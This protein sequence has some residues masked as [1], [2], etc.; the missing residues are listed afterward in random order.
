MAAERGKKR[1]CVSLQFMLSL[2][3]K[4]ACVLESCIFQG[5]STNSVSYAQRKHTESPADTNAR[6]HTHTAHTFTGGETG[7]RG[8]G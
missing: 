4:C 7:T 8:G 5:V 1:L 3:L 2:R 6:A